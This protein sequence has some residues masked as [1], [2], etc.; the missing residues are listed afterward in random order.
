MDV[1]NLM[2]EVDTTSEN[3]EMQRLAERLEDKAKT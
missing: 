3:T 2:P 1:S